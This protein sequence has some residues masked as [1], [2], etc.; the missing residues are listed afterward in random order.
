MQWLRVILRVMLARTLQC[1]SDVGLDDTVGI[2]QQSEAI[3]AL[4]SEAA[5]KV[6]PMDRA[7]GCVKG[8]GV[9]ES[10]VKA[11]AAMEE[12]EEE[13]EEKEEVVV[14]VEVE[15][16]AVREE[17][18]DSQAASLLS[19]VLTFKTSDA[20]TSVFS[21]SREISPRMISSFLSTES[22]ILGG[23]CSQWCREK[24]P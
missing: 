17:M 6:K 4:T 1:A 12:E 23:P 3:R 14:E 9:S 21:R 2:E 8:E 15:E 16:E 13:V 18:V 7:G 19:R 22:A 24:Q 11:G 5:R 20:I 10:K